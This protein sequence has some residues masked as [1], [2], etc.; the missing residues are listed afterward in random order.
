MKKNFEIKD[1]KVEDIEEIKIFTP[2]GVKTFDIEK[3]SQTEGRGRNLREKI[4][5]I[6]I[7][8]FE[9]SGVLFVDNEQKEKVDLTRQLVRPLIT[10]KK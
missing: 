8:I 5:K 7:R 1:I 2:E 9:E 3:L 6:L 10:Y 4:E